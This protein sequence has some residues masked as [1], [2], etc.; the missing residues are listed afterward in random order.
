MLRIM[1]ITSG[2]IWRRTRTLIYGAEKGAAKGRREKKGK[3]RRDKKEMRVS[4][5]NKSSI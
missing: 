5:I 3:R 2:S 4:S 1:R